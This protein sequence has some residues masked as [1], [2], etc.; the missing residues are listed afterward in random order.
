MRFRS[1]ETKKLEYIHTLN[2]SGLAT[3]RLMVAL[4]EN[5]QQKNGTIIV[6][7]PLEKYMGRSTISSEL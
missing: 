3:P 4:L 2:G 1:S 7:K 6:P 5:F